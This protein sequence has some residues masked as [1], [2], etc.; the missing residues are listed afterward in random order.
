MHILEE[1]IVRSSRKEGNSMVQR[2]VVVE[3][4]LGLVHSVLVFDAHSEVVRKVAVVRDEEGIQVHEMDRTPEVG[5]GCNSDKEQVVNGLA[6]L[7]KAFHKRHLGWMILLGNSQ[8]S[9]MVPESNP[10]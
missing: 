9:K 5:L 8:N 2:V 7:M 3:T 1:Q 6:L 10:H 4:T